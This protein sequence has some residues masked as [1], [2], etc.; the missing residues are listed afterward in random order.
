MLQMPTRDQESRIRVY[1]YQNRIFDA[2]DCYRTDNT[3]SDDEAVEFIKLY[4]ARLRLTPGFAIK[5][6][7]FRALLVIS[8]A[9]YPGLACALAGIV[10]ASA[11]G[12]D[13]LQFGAWAFLVSGILT[14]VLALAV[15]TRAMFF[16]MGAG[17]CAFSGLAVVVGIIVGILRRAFF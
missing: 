17:F 7:L 5:A 11:F 12:K 4:T 16:T 6:V 2:I 14:G 1:I 9:V 10:W 8:V 15:P 3:C 13:V